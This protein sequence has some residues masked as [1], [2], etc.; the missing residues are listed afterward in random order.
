MQSRWHHRP[1][2]HTHDSGTEKRP[3]W[4]ELFYDLVYVAAF[5]Q[6][7]N[8]LAKH[9]SAEGFL[10]F[11]SVF[12]PLWLAWT[13]FTWFT[14]RFTVDDFAHRLLVFGQMLLVGA[15]A[16]FAP[17]VL[18]SRPERFAVAYAGAQAVIALLH[19]R[20]WRETEEGRDYSLYWGAT[21]GIGA[22]LW[23]AS[24]A[25]EPPWTYVLWG[26]GLL[27]ILAAPFSATS[28]AL[29]ERYPVDLEHLTERYGLLTLI[30]LGES[31]VKVLS[32]ITADVA[33][34]TVLVEAAMTLLITVSLWWIYF[35]DVAGSRLK[36]IRL[37]PMIWLFA[38]IPLQL[39]ITAVGVAL[40]KAA[41]LDLG[42]PAPDGARWLL[43]GALG[44]TFLAV[45]VLDSVTER[46]QAE[47]SDRW[48][49]VMRVGSAALLLLL[50]PVGGTLSAGAFL[51]IVT[52]LCVVQV[53]FDMMMAPLEA[54]AHGPAAVSTAELHRRRV[55]GESTPPPLGDPLADVVR[56]GTP[57]ALRRDLYSYL[58]EGSWG[59]VLG[60][61]LFLYVV[62]NVFF[63]ALYLLEP[64][65]IADARADSF[66]DAFSFSVQTMATIG[67]GRLNPVTPYADALV[68]VEAAVGLIGAAFATGL[69]FA[70]A[71]RP[72]SSALFS[73]VAVVTPMNGVP[74]LVFRIGNARGNDIVDATVN[75]TALCDT[76]TPEG[77]H[78]RRQF[79]LKLMRSNSPFFRLSWTVMHPIDEHSPLRHIDWGHTDTSLLGILA[80]MT[81]HDG[82][83][84]TTVYARQSWSISDIRPGERFVDVI[85]QLPDG[86]LMVDYGQFHD[87]VPDGSA[88]GG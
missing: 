88:V 12:V 48:R 85:S 69:V 2:L 46:R 66:A 7:G 72:R 8:G 63:G 34:P 24:V 22:V 79:D 76:V 70:K 81:G 6:L 53:G 86:R 80:V 10:A 44:L 26:A 77:E 67:F 61:L 78:L 19:L 84:G 87:T 41:L 13:G 4:L 33:T 37:G 16:I 31:F 68:A 58:M 57:S 60:V 20:T 59:R 14:N 1:V 71:S 29:T 28:R 74:T 35:D 43:C 32:G 55:A 51:G 17:E 5:I 75:L 38:H 23:A 39:G 42:S 36:R 73:K 56:K 21:F 64:G 18:D 40:K 45:A 52:A 9:P 83:Y 15:M 27:A 54:S 25:L 47:L 49:V 82:T 30:V 3:G 50:A 65:C 62:V 11:S